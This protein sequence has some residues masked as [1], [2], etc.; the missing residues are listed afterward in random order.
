MDRLTGKTVFITGAGGGIGSATCRRFI[1]EGAQV[2]ACD[3]DLQAAQAAVAGAEAGTAIAIEL[4]AGQ[5]DAMR[6]AVEQTVEQFGQLT[7]LCNVAGGSSLDDGP[8]TE[9]NEDEFWRV[10]R[11]DLFGTFL[12]C[13][14]GIPELI[15]A[16]GGSVINMTSMMALMALPG[17]DCYTAAKGGV[18]SLT[19]SLAAE[20]GEH[21]VR[22]NAIAPGMTLSP[23]VKERIDLPQVRTIA[24]RHLLGVADPI[25]IAHMALYLAS[26]ESRV[27][28]GQILQVDSGVTIH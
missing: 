28:T 9:V 7:T 11:I 5:S 2:A 25:D 12:S 23:R 4:D 14:F 17:R 1:E 10:I 24:E 20:Y 27:V 6:A 13:R 22:V 19:R 15:K 18:A 16:G 8:V 26:D 21:S 3:I